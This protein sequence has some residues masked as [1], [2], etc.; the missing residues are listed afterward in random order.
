MPA[1]SEFVVDG[2][3]V[4][5]VQF[6][7]IDDAGVFVLEGLALNAFPQVQ[8]RVDGKDGLG[9][10]GKADLFQLSHHIWCGSGQVEVMQVIVERSLH[11][12]PVLLP[13]VGDVFLQVWISPLTRPAVPLIGVVLLVLGKFV[14]LNINVDLVQGVGTVGDVLTGW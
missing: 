10:A 8:V 4:E 3:V 12:N 7:L 1:L 11:L 9:P 13:V 6:V 2:A 5:G 14:E